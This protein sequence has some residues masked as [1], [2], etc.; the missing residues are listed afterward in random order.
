MT[1][2]RVIKN[3]NGYY[4][5][6]C[7][8]GL[9]ECRRRGRMKAKVVVGD[10]VEITE[11][12]NG[13]GVVEAVLPRRNALRRPAV[14][15][16]DQM[17]I[18]MAARSPDPNR[19]LVDKM[20]MTCEYD[21]IHP[22]LCFNKCD[23]DRQQA[24]RYAA[25][26]RKCGYEVYLASAHSGEGLA[27]LRAILPRQMTAFAGP[28]GVGKSSLLARLL[29]RSDLSVG[30]VSEKI[31][32]GRHTTRHSEIMEFSPDTFVVD[33]P[34]FSAL[35]FEHLAET[36]VIGLFPDLA[37]YAGQCRFSSCRHLTEPDCSVKAALADGLIQPER[38]ETY[39]KIITSLKERK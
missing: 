29:G 30:A 2:G 33:T 1:T 16:I 17:V 22:K 21:H 13:K 19:F 25:F 11:L 36:E 10:I 5:V 37:A 3:Y 12:G 35:D 4:Y 8:G 18:I 27:A 14:A 31:G 26:Y 24:E 6:R 15:N 7:G 39:C 9:T 28:S 38:Y 20:L 23:L 34:G 32:R